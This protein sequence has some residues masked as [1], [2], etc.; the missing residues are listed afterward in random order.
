MVDK[1][2]KTKP[3]SNKDDPFYR[4]NGYRNAP[5]LASR[6]PQFTLTDQLSIVSSDEFKKYDREANPYGLRVWSG[7]YFERLARFFYGGKGRNLRKIIAEANEPALVVFDLIDADR[8]YREV[9][10]TGKEAKLMDYQVSRQA[11][12]L[13]SGSSLISSSKISGVPQVMYDLVMHNLEGIEKNVNYRKSLL[14]LFF[15]FPEHTASMISLPLSV[16]L[17]AWDPREGRCLFNRFKGDEG[18]KSCTRF[19]ISVLKKFLENPEEGL[20]SLNLDPS[21]YKWNKRKSPPNL[22]FYGKEYAPFAILQILEK[23]PRDMLAK[24]RQQDM[25]WLVQ[26]ADLREI[27]KSKTLEE[28]SLGPLFDAFDPEGGASL[29]TEEGD[30]S[31]DVTTLVN[32]PEDDLPF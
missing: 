25:S 32:P 4:L 29:E 18:H 31:F 24:F 9:K 27:P 6:Y 13:W 8:I 15:D 20:T 23:N 21:N 10:S 26:Y 22:D 2:D 16:V 19:P 7:F 28:R 3:E 12:L 30:T 5:V 1:K 11:H 17:K 14:S